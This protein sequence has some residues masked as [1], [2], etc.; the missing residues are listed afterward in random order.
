MGFKTA[1]GLLVLVQLAAGTTYFKETFGAD[2]EKTWTPSTAKPDFGKFVLSSGKFYGDKEKDQGIQTSQDA[3]FYATSASFDAF[4]NEGKS[5]V[6]QF[7]VKHEQ[8]IDCGGGYVKVMPPM[9]GTKLDGESPYHIMFGPDICGAT[10]KIHFIFGYKGQNLLWKKEPR[11]ETDTLSHTYTA[12]VNPDGTYEV[13]VDGEK[14]ESG[15]LEE[16]WDFLKPKT[17]PDPDD[18]KPADWVDEAQMPDPEDKKPDDY[19]SQ[20]AEIADPEAEQP[21]D[22]DEEEDGKWEAPMIP[23]P[24]FKGEWK[25]K[26]I[27]NPDYKGVWKPA[28]I[29]NPDYVEDPN[30]GQ[31]SD[32]GTIAIDL[33]QVKSGSIFDNIIITDSADEAKAFY[34]ETNGATKEAEKKMMDAEEEARRAKEEAERLAREEEEKNAAGED[35]D[36]EDDEEEDDDDKK[37]EL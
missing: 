29:P 31:Y 20:P 33:W 9:D 5:V 4:S 10:K 36:D 26:M 13:L 17:I 1:L 35:E 28:E 21:E 32:F 6:V 23:N 25:P 24:D 7:S 19:D 14:K 30:L 16:D 27:P 12:I 2:W 37:D 34:D 15:T 3:K 8:N 22:W 11:C 18:K